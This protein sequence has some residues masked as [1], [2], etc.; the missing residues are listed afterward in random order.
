MSLGGENINKEN[1]EVNK[2]GRKAISVRSFAGTFFLGTEKKAARTDAKRPKS[3][4][5]DSETVR[6]ESKT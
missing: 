1:K 2:E 4:W 6:Q 5:A 3:H